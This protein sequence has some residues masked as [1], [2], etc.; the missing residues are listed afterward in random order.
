MGHCRNISHCPRANNCIQVLASEL[1]EHGWDMRWGRCLHT[2]L[3]LPLVEGFWSGVFGPGFQAR[4]S[5]RD[6]SVVEVVE[7]EK[8]AT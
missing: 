7:E 6:I 4:H 2:W 5:V 1:K 8:P 3:L